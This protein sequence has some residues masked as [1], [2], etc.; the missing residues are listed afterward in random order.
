MKERKHSLHP[1]RN[2]TINHISNGSPQ[3][4]NIGG[5][6]TFNTPVFLWPFKN[7]YNEKVLLNKHFCTGQHRCV[8]PL[9][10]IP[11]WN[12]SCV[13]C[14]SLTVNFYQHIFQVGANDSLLRPAK[15]NFFKGT[16]KARITKNYWK[17]G[18]AAT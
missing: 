2:V 9:Y 8:T 17:L 12:L 10:R 16:F 13:M 14:K 11:V 3:Y 15:T 18:G 4:K 7:Y 1:Q 6:I 5:S